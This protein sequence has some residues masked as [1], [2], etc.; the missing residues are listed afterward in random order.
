MMGFA[1]VWHIWWLASVPIIGI[2]VALLAFAW[3]VESETTIPAAL[4]ARADQDRA[5]PVKRA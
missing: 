5:A 1:L 2:V 3:R 4:L